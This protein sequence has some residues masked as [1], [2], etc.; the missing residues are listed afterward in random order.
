MTPFALG[1]LI[2]SNTY[3]V[4]D[5]Q[6]RS[7][8]PLWAINTDVVVAEE[9]TGVR[10]RTVCMLLHSSLPC[11]TFNIIHSAAEVS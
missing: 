5:A 4:F 1:Q 6:S 10:Q 9:T 7:S 11:D 2:K 3:S 8:L